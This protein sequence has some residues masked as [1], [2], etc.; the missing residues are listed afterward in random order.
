V[1]R[2]SAAPGPLAEQFAG[3]ALQPTPEEEDANGVSTILE[4]ECA[5]E[6]GD[7]QGQRAAREALIGAALVD[8][9]VEVGT[10]H[11]HRR[12]EEEE[13]GGGG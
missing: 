6:G 7:G 1:P 12:V 9:R 2:P 13:G 10:R 8:E 11:G 3:P 5:G 4:Q